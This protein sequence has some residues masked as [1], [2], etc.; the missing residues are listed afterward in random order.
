LVVTVKVALLAP[1]GMLTAA[2]TCATAVLLL[3]RLTSAPP[4]G[5]I[6]FNAAVPVELFPPTTEVGFKV[7]EDKLAVFTLRVALRVTT[8]VPEMTADV[9]ADTTLVVMVKVAEILNAGMATDGGTCA[10]EVL[11]LCRVTSTP[12]AGAALFN[13]TVPVE[14]FPPTTVPGLRVREYKATAFIVRTAL[15]VTPY[16]PEITTVVLLDTTLVVMVKV[17]EALPAGMVTDGS[18]CATEVLLLCNVT[19]APPAGAGPFKVTVPVALFPPVTE[20]G[21][22][23]SEDRDGALTVSVAL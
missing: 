1:A 14:L 3:V 7:I 15:R 19:N 22:L 17:A 16:V 13:A 21:L 9:F 18:T 23:V 5:A 6:P 11:L 20:L 8:N 12:P 4:A 10:T 2:G